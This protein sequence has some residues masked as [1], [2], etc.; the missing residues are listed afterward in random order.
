MIKNQFDIWLKTVAKVKIFGI[1]INWI[2][3][4][5]TNNF[6]CSFTQIKKSNIL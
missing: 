3:E 4:N 1:N 6:Y 2:N 5:T